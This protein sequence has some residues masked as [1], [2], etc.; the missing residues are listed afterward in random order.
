MPLARVPLLKAPRTGLRT[1]AWFPEPLFP[2]YLFAGIE[3]DAMFKVADTRGVGEVDSL[4]NEPIA[5]HESAFDDLKPKCVDGVV[6]LPPQRFRPDELVKIRLGA[7][8]GGVAIFGRD[9]L[10]DER[11]AIMLRTVGTTGVRV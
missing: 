10:T 7:F 8:R 6:E 11:V 2:C 4:A 9:L 3:P 1:A 5:V